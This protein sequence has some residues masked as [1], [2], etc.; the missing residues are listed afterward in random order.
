MPPKTRKQSGD[1]HPD[2]VFPPM[3]KFLHPFKLPANKSI[4]GVLQTLLFKGASHVTREDA[5]REV[6]K[7]TIA[8]WY[9]DTVF[10][11]GLSAVVDRILKL[12]DTFVKGRKRFQEGRQSGNEIE[13]YK[14]LVEKAD[15]LFDI[16]AWTARTGALRDACVERCKAEWCVTMSENEFRYYEDMK[17]DRKMHC[18]H[19]LDPVHYM[20]F[21]RRE[22]MRQREEEY[23]KQRAEQFA[24]KPIEECTE[25]L[26]AEM[27]QLS[28]P[29]VS[30]ETPE[31]VPASSPQ[32]QQQSS[33]T[34]SKKRKLFLDNE[35]V[36]APRTRSSIAATV[37]PDQ[38][39]PVLPPH[40]AHI[41]TSEKKVRDEFYL[42]M[43]SLVGRGL[44]FM[45]SMHAVVDVGRGMFNTSWKMLD[46]DSDTYDVDTL[47]DIANVSKQLDLIEAETLSFA[48]DK[49]G[50]GK[51]AGRP[52]T[53]AIDSTTKKGVGQFATQGISIGRETPIPLPLIPICGEST[54]D[55]AMQVALIIDILAAVKGVP[56]EEIYKLIDCH[57]TDSV[58]H[59]KGINLVL[60]AIYDLDEPAGQL[61]CG[62]HTTL[63]FSAAMNKVVSILERDMGIEKVVK[64]FMVD[65]DME[66]KNGSFAGQ[67]LDICLRLVAPEF[68]HK[69]WNYN[70]LFVNF[71]QQQGAENSLFCYKD[72]RFGALS[73]ASGVL[74]FNLPFLKQFL[75]QNPNINNKL[76]CLTR[77]CLELPYLEVVMATF[78]A[79]GIHV[80]EPFFA[81]TI[82]KSSTHSTLKEFYTKLHSDLGKV[83]SAEFFSLE[84]PVLES[85]TMELFS[86]VLQGYG[87]GV[88][89]AVRDTAQDHIED[90]V[91]LLNLI[92]PAMQKC[93]A[94]QRRD[95]SLSDEFPAEYP[96]FD[97]AKNIDDTP[98]HNLAM[99]NQ[100]G[101]VDYRLHKQRT[102]SAVGR[103]LI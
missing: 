101:T 31:K 43:S 75:D 28:S 87:K 93:L 96:V 11:L 79:I 9:H 29:D 23:R 76:A 85:E 95:Y 45:E 44:S 62:S 74:L 86:G 4:I 27:G 69:P 15:E 26:V 19:G 7:L 3:E 82:D 68:S 52:I 41:R 91:G 94:K 5:A 70:G 16:S 53:A 18:D 67:A 55:V 71:L 17:K 102:L 36:S 2:V 63:G 14:A 81:K 37:P 90:C 84:S 98:V 46:R 39:V 21:M 89:A 58:A 103:Y 35:T 88:V 100:C 20:A 47:P 48:V 64:N 6:A 60:A 65:I 83:Q 51:A 38:E 49:I 40:L 99:E 1:I 59:N 54:E 32:Q 25:I 80:I 78:A 56:R 42:T 57:M 77:E 92:F 30:T 73:K 10:C 61:Y 34:Q 24:M 8:K 22:R 72:Q 33:G 66:T 12:W 13:N 50:E 97:Q